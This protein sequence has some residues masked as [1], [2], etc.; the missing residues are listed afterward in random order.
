MQ[1]FFPDTCPSNLIVAGDDFVVHILK[2]AG[3][4]E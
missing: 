3:I 2:S 1:G 4:D